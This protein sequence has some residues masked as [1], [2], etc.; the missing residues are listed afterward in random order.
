MVERQLKRSRYDKQNW[1]R[2]ERRRL[3]ELH[4]RYGIAGLQRRRR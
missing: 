3:H 2:R 1:V 4:R